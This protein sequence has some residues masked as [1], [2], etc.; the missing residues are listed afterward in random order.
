MAEILPFK[1]WRYNQELSKNLDSLTAPLFDVVSERQR[2][3]LYENPLNSIHISVPSGD[4]PALKAKATLERWKK[5]GVITQDLIPGIYVYYQYFRVPGEH[6]ERC[7]KG[8]IAQ[9]KAYDWEEK[10]ILRHENTIVSAVGDRMDLLRE[11]LFQSSPTHGLYE[12]SENQLE[13]FMDAAMESPL[14]EVEDYQGVREVVAVIQ[15]ADVIRKFL[16]VLGSKKVI[17]ADGHHRLQSAISFRKENHDSSEEEWTASDFHMMYLTNAKG[18]HIQILPTHRLFYGLELSE[19]GFLQKVEDWFEVKAF[20]DPEELEHYAFHTQGKFGLVFKESCF[21]IELK[22]EKFELLN[23]NKA[24][25]VRKLDLAI[26]HDALFDRVLGIPLE[27]QRKSPKIAY[28]RNFTRC[29]SEVRSGRA[30]FAVIARELEM[31]QVLEVC[32]SGE[33]MP[34]KSTYFY[35]K[36]LGGLVMASIDQ[37]EFNFDYGAFFRKT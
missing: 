18:N 13:R 12:D 21:L 5:D 25:P 7:R 9:I 15:D 36:A 23:Q 14:Y 11:T 33:V 3:L 34:Q 32:N 1:G 10:K 8:F 2:Q 6:N 17:L 16:E 35:P 22:P 19:E 24:E 27:D 31:E 29:L 37:E 28:E 26:L 20:G 4:N 30:S